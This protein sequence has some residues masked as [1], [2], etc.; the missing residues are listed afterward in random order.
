[1]RGRREGRREGERSTCARVDGSMCKHLHQA[2]ESNFKTDKKQTT[3][4]HTRSKPPTFTHTHTHTSSVRPSTP[5]AI[6]PYTV[7]QATISPWAQ[8]P[9]SRLGQT[10]RPSLGL[11]KKEE[12]EEEGRRLWRW[13]G[14]RVRTMWCKCFCLTTPRPHSDPWES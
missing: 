2:K 13:P 6:A 11:M 7:W 1:M 3:F 14:R 8:P 10:R 4:F 12:K 9:F 5:T